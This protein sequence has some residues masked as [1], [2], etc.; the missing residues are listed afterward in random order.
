MGLGSLSFSLAIQ[1]AALNAGLGL[2]H[3]GV[4]AAKAVRPSSSGGGGLFDLRAAVIPSE[5]EERNC[6]PEASNSIGGQFQQERRT[7]LALD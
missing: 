2:S 1:F 4:T 3:L 5:S 7:S 6:G